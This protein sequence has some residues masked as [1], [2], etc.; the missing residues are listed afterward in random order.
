MTRIEKLN[1]A[2]AGYKKRQFCAECADRMSS[3]DWAEVRYC[4]KQ[5]TR[6]SLL[7]EKLENRKHFGLMPP[8]IYGRAN[9][10]PL[11]AFLQEGQR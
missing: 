3:S 10:A 5:M 9:T 2:Y 7:I 8:L 1:A 11:E 6:I 4:D